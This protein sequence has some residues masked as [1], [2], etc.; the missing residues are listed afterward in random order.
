MTSTSMPS[1]D[2]FPSC[3]VKPC[4]AHMPFSQPSWLCT[5]RSSYGCAIRGGRRGVWEECGRPTGLAW[6]CS[7]RAGP[8]GTSLTRKNSR[9][10]DWHDQCKSNKM[11]QR[12]WFSIDVEHDTNKRSHRFRSTISSIVEY[13]NTIKMKPQVNIIFIWSNE[14]ILSQ[15]NVLV[16]FRVHLN[17]ILKARVRSDR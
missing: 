12:Q 11:F 5:T 8:V 4:S 9:S 10:C 2:P 15:A 6:A 13:K 1:A 7:H 16:Y 3:A 14:R 17:F